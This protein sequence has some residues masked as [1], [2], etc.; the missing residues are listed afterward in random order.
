MS[1]KSNGA[2]ICNPYSVESIREAYIKIITGVICVDDIMK[3][4][5]K[6]VEKYRLPIVAKQ[7]FELYKSI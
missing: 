7:Y 6:N 1:M 4:G 5:L 2:I 3:K